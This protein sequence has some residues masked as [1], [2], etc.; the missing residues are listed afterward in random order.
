MSEIEPRFKPPCAWCGVRVQQAW[1]AINRARRIGAPVYCGKECGGHGR[2]KGLSEAEK[3]QAKRLYDMEY[4]AS[5]RALLKKKKRAYHERTYDPKAAAIKRAVLMPRHVEYCRRPEYRAKKHEYDV[6][7]IAKVAY[8]PFA[9]AFLT[10]RAIEREVHERASDY[11]VRLANGTL[12]K[13]IQ[14]S[15]DAA[16]NR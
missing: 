6:K 3:K 12:N 10:L 9:E 4:R 8:G 16:A 11:D 13:K 15:R 14:R 5:N 7:R 2:R 1:G